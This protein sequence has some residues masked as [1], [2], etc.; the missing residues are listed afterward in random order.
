MKETEAKSIPLTH[1]Y[2]TAHCPGLVVI[3]RKA[4][5]TTLAKWI[6]N[7]IGIS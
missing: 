4:K 5:N 2:K 3:N 7:Q 1:M 6:Q